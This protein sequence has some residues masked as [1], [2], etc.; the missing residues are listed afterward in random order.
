MGGICLKGSILRQLREQKGLTQAELGKIL[1][2]SQTAISHYETDTDTPSREIEKAIAEFFNVSIEYLNGE[3]EHQALGAQLHEEY[4]SGITLLQ[5]LQDMIKL[6][7]KHRISLVDV[8]QSFAM[9]GKK[10]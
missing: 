1:H 3:S 5:I 9:T 8:I 2:I 10:K 4:A 7:P 6:S